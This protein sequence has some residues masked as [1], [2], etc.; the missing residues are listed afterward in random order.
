V[1]HA[2]DYPSQKVEALPFGGDLNSVYPHQPGY[3]RGWPPIQ[4]VYLG[5]Y[6]AAIGCKSII[7]E[8]HY[9]DRDYIEDF[10]LFYA[11]S[12]KSY[13]NYC[14]RLHFFSEPIDD[15]RWK[16]LVHTTESAARKRAK[17]W[18]QERYLGF[19]VNRPLPGSP[20]GRTVVTTFPQTTPDGK[21]RS[22][23]CVRDY[24]VHLGGYEL[25]VRGLAFQQQDQGVSACATTALWSAMH[26]TAYL[27]GITI[28]TPASITEAAS[29]YLLSAGRALPSDG[30]DVFQLCE[31]TRAVGLAP[32]LID[33]IWMRDKLQLH[34]YIRSGFAPVLALE[35]LK[36]G[37]GH[38]VCAVGLKVGAIPPQENQSLHFREAFR[39]I[40]AIYL[41]DDRIGPYA[42][43]DLYG[44]TLK[45]E[46]DGLPAPARLATGLRIRWPGQETEEDHSVLLSFV[47]PVPPK[48]RLTAN[49]LQAVGLEIAEFTGTE[50]FPKD[51]IV[52]SYRYAKAINY[53]QRAID[54]GL[55]GPGLYTMTSECVWS[56]YIGIVEFAGIE[57]ALFD[58]ILDATE[59]SANPAILAFVRRGDP[60][61]T[62]FTRLRELAKE[63]KARFLT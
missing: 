42:T 62:E 16:E 60:N 20:V 11:R 30:L 38:A 15:E 26:S 52:V 37:S 25:K 3:L 50:V 39:A 54:F 56:R 57:G 12:L 55:S 43:A 6:L 47:I 63:V 40:E 41:H 28:A 53:Q 17:E 1:A 61:A 2:Q 23:G 32:Q 51:D 44:Y 13:K 19:S 8:S 59:T 14:E 18:L 49:T 24:R 29:R 10:A 46:R 9:V 34:T 45:Q 58:V 5:D 7:R 4:V 31:A 27:E 48:V 35:S 21:R 33:G 36:N 22:F